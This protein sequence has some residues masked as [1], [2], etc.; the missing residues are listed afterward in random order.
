MAVIAESCTAMRSLPRLMPYVQSTFLLTP[1]V[2]LLLGPEKAVTGH[3]FN[4][5]TD[6]EAPT[7]NATVPPCME[8]VLNKEGEF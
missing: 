3:A 4:V 6:S 5:A 8:T 2:R 7:P 1:D